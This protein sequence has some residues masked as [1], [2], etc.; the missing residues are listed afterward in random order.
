M[1][2]IPWCPGGVPVPSD[3]R[4]VAV[5]DGKPA[6]SGPASGRLER[7][8]ASAAYRRSS[9]APSPSTR[10]R[11][12]RAPAGSRGRPR[13]ARHPERAPSAP[14]A[15]RPATAR[16]TGGGR[17]RAERLRSVEV[18][19][20]SVSRSGDGRGG[21]STVTTGAGPV[22]H[23]L[24]DGWRVVVDRH[25]VALDGGRVL[26][27]G[28]PPRMLRLA[29]AGRAL[30]AGGGFTVTDATSAGAGQAAARRRGR[31]P[32]PGRRR[33]R[34]AG[35]SPS[36]SRSRTGPTPSPACSP[37]SRRTWAA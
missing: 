26:L 23:A 34:A 12:A 4:L 15:P 24:P 29:P 7:N 11:P 9:R 32:G 17:A 6:V 18:T 19:R 28:A 3:V 21:G 10:S 33:A 20:V 2:T 25:V 31:A 30:L 35:T 8:G 5:L 22:G 16:R 37:R 13:T 36:S 1:P 14:A 27:G